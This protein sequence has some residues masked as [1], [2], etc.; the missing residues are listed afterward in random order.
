MVINGTAARIFSGVSLPAL[1]EIARHQSDRFAEVYFRMRWL[2]DTLLV[3]ASGV[4]FASGGAIV[5]LLFDQR[6][7]PAGDMLHWLSVGLLFSRYGL[8]INAYVALGRTQYTTVINAVN[9]IS[10]FTVV[11]TL[12]YFLGIKGAIIGLAIQQAPM[13]PIIF[14][15]NEKHGL[16]N[17][18]QEVAVLALWPIGWLAADLAVSNLPI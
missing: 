12:F 6:Y 10:L 14:W 5:R 18:K 16:N 4:L 15:L 1:S 13:V 2:C 9:V 17:F 8:T 7:E 3:S 11:P